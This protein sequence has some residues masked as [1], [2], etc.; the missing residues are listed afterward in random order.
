MS[1]ALE[2]NLAIIIIPYYK[3]IGFNAR[4]GRSIKYIS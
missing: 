1:T 4:Y 2:H 3:H